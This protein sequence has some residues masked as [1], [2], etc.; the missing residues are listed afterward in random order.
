MEAG[1]GGEGTYTRSKA[2]V[3]A[4]RV[5]CRLEIITPLNPEEGVLID[6]RRRTA[7]GTIRPTTIH[8]LV[9]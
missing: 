1:A 4:W 7:W 2:V 9:L 3:I 8:A 6:T 5:R